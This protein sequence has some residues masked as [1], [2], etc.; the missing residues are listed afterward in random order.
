VSEQEA[1]IFV[2][3]SECCCKCGALLDYFETDICSFCD[4]EEAREELA[5][6]YKDWW[7]EED[8]ITIGTPEEAHAVAMSQ[9]DYHE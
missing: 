2:M 7:T 8:E 9:E 3:D 5:N 4:E 6:S 1:M